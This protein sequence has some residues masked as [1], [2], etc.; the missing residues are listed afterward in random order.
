MSLAILKGASDL[1]LPGDQIG[2]RQML[3]SEVFSNFV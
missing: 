2:T 3:A 1:N